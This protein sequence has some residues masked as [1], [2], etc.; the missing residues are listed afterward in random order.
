MPLLA[1]LSLAPVWQPHRR[2]HLLKLPWAD[3][4]YHANAP[5]YPSSAKQRKETASA[6][7]HIDLLVKEGIELDQNY[8]FKYCSPT[9]CSLQTGR[10]PVHVNVMNL[11]PVNVNP[12]DPIGGFSAAPPNM[13]GI[14]S[15]MKGA[16]YA[17]AFAGEN[18]ESTTPHAHAKT[19]HFYI[20]PVD[21]RQMGCR[22][23]IDGPDTARQ[24]VRPV[25]PL[26]SP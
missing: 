10:N 18:R 17:T 1:I 26:L 8:V 21:S 9:R 24:G 25:A 7:P 5:G 3:R 12:D 23:G 14:A 2:L 4:R 15:V 13:T 19:S 6:T 22:H 20:A 11:D 16:G